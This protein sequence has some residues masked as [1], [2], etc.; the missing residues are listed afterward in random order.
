VNIVW[1]PE[2]IEDLISLRAYVGAEDSEAAR[3]LAMR[4]VGAIETLVSQNPEIG[5]RGRVRGTRELVVA[6]TSYIAPYRIKEDAI[7]VLRIPHG[8][9]RWPERF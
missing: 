5:R 7:E 4:I 3:R 8:S 6:R 2:A 1:S 9:R